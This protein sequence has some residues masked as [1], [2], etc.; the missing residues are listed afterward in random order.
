[1]ALIRPVDDTI[2]AFLLVDACD[3]VFSKDEQQLVCT[4]AYD[5][6]FGK[7]SNIPLGILILFNP[8][9]RVGELCALKWQDIETSYKG[10]YIHVQ[11]E[12]VNNITDD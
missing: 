5:E 11:R 1:M 7:N 6:A 12:V 2:V 9:L 10:T 3:T 4:S 8:G